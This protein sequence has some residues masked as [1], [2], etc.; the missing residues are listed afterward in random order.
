MTNNENFNKKQPN[1]NKLN[2]SLEEVIC[3]GT[4]C[5]CSGK[6]FIIFKRT[7]GLGFAFVKITCFKP[8]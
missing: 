7:A 3:R 1:N 4:T 6:P 8:I 2:L 5:D